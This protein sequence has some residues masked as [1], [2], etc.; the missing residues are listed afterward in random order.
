MTILHLPKKTTLWV[1]PGTLD[2]QY[3]YYIVGTQRFHQDWYEP[4]YI[5]DVE[6]QEPVREALVTAE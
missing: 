5:G 4:R 3:P 6:P 1:E 2:Y